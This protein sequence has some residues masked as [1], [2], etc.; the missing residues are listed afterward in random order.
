[1]KSIKNSIIKKYNGC[2]LA[3]AIS[4]I[5]TMFSLLLLTLQLAN[6]IWIRYNG[7]LVICLLLTASVLT[8]ILKWWDLDDLRKIIDDIKELEKENEV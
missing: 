2:K 6:V 3:V 8:L 1:M 7:G 5:F 4:G